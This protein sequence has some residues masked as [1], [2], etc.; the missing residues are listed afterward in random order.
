MHFKIK[1]VI[2]IDL[3]VFWFCVLDIILFPFFFLISVSYSLP[4][5]LCWTVCKSR[6]IFK[7]RQNKYLLIA[8]CLIA[9]SIVMCGFLNP[10]G[11]RVATSNALVLVQGFCYYW[12]FEY[13]FKRRIINI[14]AIFW[15]FLIF[16]FALAVLYFVNPDVLFQL[17]IKW[18]P[19]GNAH[20]LDTYN[21]AKKWGERWRFCFIWQDPNNIAYFI[22]S[23]TTYIWM[24]MKT[25]ISLKLFSALTAVVVLIASMSSG[26]TLAAAMTAFLI[27]FFGIYKLLLNHKI[28]SGKVKLGL[29]IVI[30]FAFAVIYIISNIET[31]DTSVLETY[32]GRLGSNS[33]SYRLVIWKF[34]IENNNWPMH[35]FFGLGP[36]VSEG[37]VYSTHN[38]HLWLILQYGLPVF[39]IF[40]FFAF[41]PNS[42][43]KWS[44]YFWVI[45]VFIGFSINIMITG[46]KEMGMLMLLVALYRNEAEE[47]RHFEYNDVCLQRSIN[48]RAGTTC[49]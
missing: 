35:L 16:V 21:I 26:A 46:A 17:I 48:G 25:S 10:V 43:R 6:H 28:S 3:L 32:I 19:R 30:A 8:C 24:N 23:I 13:I 37:V 27:I 38:G 5:V 1:S 42:F 29:M 39:M 20:L 34:T 11:L 41:R 47:D 12:L 9:I 31:I 2:N 45:S 44:H 40:N 7:N 33:T 22:V 4:V 36:A 15:L 18:N 49:S 14:E